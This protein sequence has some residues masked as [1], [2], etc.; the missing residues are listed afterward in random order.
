MRLGLRVSGGVAGLHRAPVEID[1]DTLDPGEAAALERLA[2]Q[3][4]AQP[5]AG[6]AP[7]ADRLQYDLLLDGRAIRAY[8]G[9]LTPEADELIRRI[10][11]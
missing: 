9:A 3:V 8:E 7:G 10:G 1:T 5:P 11:R 6:A 2:A 4:A